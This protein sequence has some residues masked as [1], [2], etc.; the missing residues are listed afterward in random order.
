MGI[1]TAGHGGRRTV[2]IRGFR[3]H[4]GLDRPFLTL[5]CHTLGMGSFHRRRLTD[6]HMET[7]RMVRPHIR[8]A[9]IV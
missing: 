6:T 2:T 9:I 3:S 8:T 5:I 1:L 7:M 4:L